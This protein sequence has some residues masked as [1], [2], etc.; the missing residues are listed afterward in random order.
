MLNFLTIYNLI[1][2]QKNHILQNVRP[3]IS[4]MFSRS[5]IALSGK[6][7]RFR[8]QHKKDD[9]SK[10][11]SIIY[12]NNLTRTNF[13]AQIVIYSLSVPTLLWSAYTC[14]KHYQDIPF[15]LTATSPAM[16]GILYIM[17]TGLLV[18][19]LNFICR[20]SIYRIYHN[21][22]TDHFVAILQ[23]WYMAKYQLPFSID[24]TRY[25]KP[26]L[27]NG[28]IGNIEIKGRQFFVVG[29]DFKQPAYYNRL[30]GWELNTPL[31][32]PSDIDLKDLLQKAKKKS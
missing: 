19:V 26:S 6:P 21:P 17:F 10:E 3:E 18:T 29:T 15:N 31:E 13:Y 23:N 27:R 24:E 1:L 2:F 30:M 11:Y 20:R 14:A 8:P 12:V 4:Y 28:F 25:Q 9:V 32:Q 7:Q 22:E 5:K 16:G